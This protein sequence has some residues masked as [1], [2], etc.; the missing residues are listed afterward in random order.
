[1][2]KIYHA[3][4][5]ELRLLRRD[6]LGFAI[7]FLMPVVLIITITFIQ[8]SVENNSAQMQLPVLLVNLDQGELSNK[9]IQNLETKNSIKIISE[10]DNEPL[11]EVKGR[12]LIKKG[13]QKVLIVIP[14]EFSDFIQNQT[15][16]HVNKLMSTVVPDME[17][18]EV[19]NEHETLV[20]EVQLHFDPAISG[21][22]KS[23]IKG[24]IESMISELET[25]AIYETFEKELDADL[26][27]LTE[28]KLIT[29]KEYSVSVNNENVEPTPVQHNLPAWTLFAIFFIVIPLSINIVKEKNQGTYIRLKTLPVSSFQ[30]MMS[31]IIV[32]LMVCM[33][34]FYLMLMV[35]VFLFPQIGLPALD[36]EGKLIG[37]T[38][39]ALFS[40]LAAIGFGVLIGTFAKTHEQAAPFGATSVVIL[41]AIGGLWFPVFAMPETMQMIA[42]I[43]PMNWALEG[44][45]NVL[46]RDADFI[47]LAPYLMLLLIFFII[48]ITI[49]A[50][51][52]KKI[53]QL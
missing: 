17:L 1:M 27:F 44:F 31:K 10:I 47:S 16:Q 15:D 48:N 8:N 4:L 5:K 9:V 3:I 26:S 25:K 24:A 7:I 28:Q 42:K 35:A 33:I 49:A 32:Y 13:T 41:A 45:Y 46:L 37:L 52:E 11:T 6:L 38:I 50:A 51:Y 22:V 2:Y 12:A 30:L 23:N 34:Q 14:E 18:D 39:V 21:N 53:N 29:F 40:G 36:V 19:V 20:K 43:S